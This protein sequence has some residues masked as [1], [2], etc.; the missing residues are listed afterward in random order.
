MDR[1][2]C[3]LNFLHCKAMNDIKAAYQVKKKINFFV[4]IF[5]KY[6]KMGVN[7]LLFDE[8]ASVFM[9]NS[10]WSDAIC[11]RFSHNPYDRPGASYASA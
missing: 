11:I 2:A 5:H 4:K 6:F 9:D 7:H 3:W 10:S 1:K 8:M